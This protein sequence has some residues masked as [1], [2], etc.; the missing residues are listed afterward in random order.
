MTFLRSKV[1]VVR[2]TTTTTKFNKIS[3]APK[4]CVAEE[5]FFLAASRAPTQ[6]LTLVSKGLRYVPD[7]VE[8]LIHLRQLNVKK[9]R[10]QALS[11]KLAELKHVR[12][13]SSKRSLG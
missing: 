4:R 5:R 8:R 12:F 2:G 9:N 1:T 3:R 7:L 10:L 6:S 13:V 11:K